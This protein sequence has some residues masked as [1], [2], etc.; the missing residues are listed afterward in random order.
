MKLS[1]AQYRFLLAVDAGF[2][3]SLPVKGLDGRKLLMVVKLVR[4]R[5][6]AHLPARGRF[7]ER[8]VV[9]GRGSHALKTFG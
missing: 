5:V 2:C 8:L 9:T 7:P 1:P 6:I 3:H 4:E